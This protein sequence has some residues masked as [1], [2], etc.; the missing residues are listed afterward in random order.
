MKDYYL[1]IEGVNLDN[2]VFDT[3]D[4][5]TIRGGGL[6]LLN[7]PQRVEGILPKETIKLKPITQ[8]ASWGLFR[9][10]AVDDKTH[11]DIVNDIHKVLESDPQYRHATI[12]VDAIPAGKIDEYPLKK[13]SL[14]ALNRWRQMSSPSVISPAASNSP[15]QPLSEPIDAPRGKVCQFDHVRPAVGKIEKGDDRFDAS[16]SVRIRREYGMKNKGLEWHQKKTKIKDLPKFVNDFDKVTSPSDGQDYGNLNGK[17]AVIYLDGNKFG[18]RQRNYCTS[19][20]K[21]EAF[22]QAIRERYQDG[23]LKTLLA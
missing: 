19:P 4:L 11:T 15:N 13:K 10:Q 3:N 8:G 23:A 17:M 14:E 21:Q 5:S 20:E 22:D 18:E 1:R 7:L 9:F 2:F 6:L 16:L 12:V